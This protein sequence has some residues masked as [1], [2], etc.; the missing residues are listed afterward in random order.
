MILLWWAYCFV[1]SLDPFN[2][3]FFSNFVLSLSLSSDSHQL[4]AQLSYVFAR[5]VDCDHRLGAHLTA[6]LTSLLTQY[7]AP[8]RV[9]LFLSQLRHSIPPHLQFGRVMLGKVCCCSRYSICTCTQWTRHSIVSFI[10]PL[11][12]SVADGHTPTYFPTDSPTVKEVPAAT[13]NPTS[14][15]VWKG[16]AWKGAFLCWCMPSL[17]S[18]YLC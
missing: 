11:S 9:P 14:S 10:F 16:D 6:F 17:L 15:P 2:L 3:F 1:V 8:P 7:R 18:R 5:K 4:W 13:S 12:L